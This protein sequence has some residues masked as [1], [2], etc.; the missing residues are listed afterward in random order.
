VLDKT[1]EYTSITLV[2]TEFPKMNESTV[3]MMFGLGVD[4]GRLVIDV[5]YER[6][7]I[8]AFY[9]YDGA[10]FDYFSVRTGILIN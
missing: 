3:G 9:K 10:N 5:E 2:G 1:L 4:L 7:L 6:G 8:N